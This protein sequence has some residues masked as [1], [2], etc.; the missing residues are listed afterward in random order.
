MGIE[1]SFYPIKGVYMDYRKA[2]DRHFDNLSRVAGRDVRRYSY[3]VSGDELTDAYI[4]MRNELGY[5]LMMDSK[6]RRAIVYNKK[7][8]EKKIMDLVQKSI[9]SNINEIEEVIANDVADDII[10][11]IEG[12]TQNGN[13]KLIKSRNSNSLNR[14]AKS[15]TKAL[16]DG[17]NYII[18]DILYGKDNK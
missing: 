4:K 15:L 11:Q 2:I 14:F 10:M 17:V 1:T 13:G 5:P 16:F 12:L 3:V 8:L 18:D 9:I 6:Y 7:G